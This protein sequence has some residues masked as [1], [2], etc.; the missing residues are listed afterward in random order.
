MMMM[1][2]VLKMQEFGWVVCVFYLNGNR[3]F[4]LYAMI[5]QVGVADGCDDV[6][7]EAGAPG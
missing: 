2:N 3:Y 4:I 7:D 6:R 1:G 5:G